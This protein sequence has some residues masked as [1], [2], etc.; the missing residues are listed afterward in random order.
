[1]ISG[2][3]AA[4]ALKLNRTSISLYQTPEMLEEMQTNTLFMEVA[5]ENI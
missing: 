3:I 2:A 5:T 1:M 4:S